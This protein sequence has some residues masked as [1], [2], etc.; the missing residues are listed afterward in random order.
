MQTV[1][2]NCLGLCQQSWWQQKRKIDGLLCQDSSPILWLSCNPTDACVIFLPNVFFSQLLSLSAFFCLYPSI[3][4]CHLH[5]CHLHSFS[6]FLYIYC[7]FLPLCPFSVVCYICSSFD[8]LAYVLLSLFGFLVC[9]CTRKYECLI[10]EPSKALMMMMLWMQLPGS[11]NELWAS[12]H[13][14]F[15]ASNIQISKK[16]Y[17]PPPKIPVTSILIKTLCLCLKCMSPIG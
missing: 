12:G 2:A 3:H 11:K 6:I 16:Y 14:E 1:M 7:C 17:R 9:E 8:W 4:A 10:P 15:I 13:N 5:A